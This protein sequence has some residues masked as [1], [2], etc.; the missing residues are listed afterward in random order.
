MSRMQINSVANVHAGLSG[1]P[2]KIDTPTV[3]PLRGGLSH[4]LGVLPIFDDE[5]PEAQ[6]SPY[7]SQQ[8]AEKALQQLIPSGAMGAN[9]P[10][11][12]DV[13]DMDPMVLSM[14]MVQLV[15]NVSGNNAS[16]LCQ[17][18]ERATEV[19]AALRNQQ[20]EKYQE[21]IN[22]AIEQTDQAR[23]AG[24]LNA[25]FDWVIGGVEVV[26][27]ALTLMRGSLS[28][29]P[30]AIADGAAYLSAGLF[31]MVKAS[32]ETAML[33]GA[34]KNDCQQVIQVAGTLQTSCEF[35]AFG[36]D[37]VQ[38]GRGISASRAV[39]KAAEEVLES[40]IGER[41]V[42]AVAT[43]AAEEVEVLAK[44]IGQEVSQEL[45]KN[46]GMAMEREMVEVGDMAI[47]AAAHEIEAEAN[48][49]RMMGKSFTREGVAEMVGSVLKAV[50]EDL[51]QKGEKVV[52]EK[53]R[54]AVLKQLRNT[55]MKQILFDVGCDALRTTQK[56]GSSVN[57][58]FSGV[59]AYKTAELQ[60]M[61]DQLITQQNFIDFMVN[62]TEERKKTQQKRLN[63]AYQNGANAMKCASDIIDSYGTVLANIAGARA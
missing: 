41:F 6:R 38:V 53:L 26:Y 33:L 19:Q 57:H 43:K 61:I 35:V 2:P 9:P 44:K 21:Q 49:V 30:L 59:I 16:A 47:E 62:W 50:G 5:N 36:L 23:K 32:A 45:G 52:A 20:V 28:G 17:Q 10:S 13:M 40:G 4:R 48:M 15:M 58:T 54:E 34:N 3:S 46:F 55:L 63:E 39:T 31:G 56:I 24:I 18:L 25:V 42:E 37:F 7:V 12:R 8:E 60:K 11:I 22:K 29:D 27:G 1:I 14:M 51:I